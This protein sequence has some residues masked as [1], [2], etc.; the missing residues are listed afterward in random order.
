M[1]SDE[2]VLREL[3]INIGVAESKGD[4]DFLSDVLAPVM[5]FRRAS[6]AFVD[7]ATF[8]SDV[9][10]SAPRE[11]EIESIKLFGRDRAVVTCI[12]SLVEGDERKRFHNLRLFV[13]SGESVWKL[14]G[15]TNDPL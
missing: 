8:L 3:N 1:R 2:D 7:R 6:G 15:W 5:A 10:E 11:T 4:R 12:V 14:L 9:K 13:R